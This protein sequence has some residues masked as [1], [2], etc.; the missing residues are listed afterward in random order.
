MTGPILLVSN[1][2]DL[3]T[4]KVVA[5][6][7][8]RQVDYHRLDLDLLAHDEI[9]LDPTE[10]LLRWT[11]GSEGAEFVVTE[12]AS[13]WYRAP[14]HLRESSGHRYS[15][16][17]LLARHQWAAFAR[18]LVV[19]ERTHWVNHPVA[20][21]AAESKAFQLRAAASLGFRVPTTSI[22][23]SV[24]ACRRLGDPLLVK[25][26]DSFLVRIDPQ[27]DLFF[28]STPMSTSELESHSLREMPV[29]SQRYFAEKADVRVTVV[30][31]RVFGSE[32]RGRVEGDWRLHGRTAQFLPSALPVEMRDMCVEYTR[33]LG[34]RY[35]AIDFLRMDDGY[36]FLEINPTG[37][38]GWL[39][40]VHEGA[41]SSALVDELIAG[42]TA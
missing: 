4:D 42:V 30:G 23:N 36:T 27:T 15:A 9:E 5:R 32:M 38:W 3:S 16:E 33:S 22:T 21:Y 7:R 37:E 19:F 18:S 10:A 41:I 25:S 8:E 29:V 14:T 24:S 40:A 34:L 11:M 1:S 2:L 17:E 31:E 28:Y 20:T 12:P 39:E 13:I 26:L 35:G 6:L